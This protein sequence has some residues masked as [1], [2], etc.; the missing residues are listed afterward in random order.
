LVLERHGA[1]DMRSLALVCAAT[2]LALAACLSG[3][4]TGGEPLFDAG[5]PQPPPAGDDAGIQ[6]PATWTALYKDYFGRGAA[7]SCSRATTCHGAE[8]HGG[9]KNSGFLC[10]PDGDPSDAGADGDAAAEA[11]A[12]SGQDRCYAGITNPNAGLVTP[13]DAKTFD[14]TGLYAVLRKQLPD[15]GTSGFM[16]QGSAFTF[17]TI[18]IKRLSDWYAAGAKND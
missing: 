13:G 2:A 10:P 5:P 1:D 4:V 16:P 7:A 18:D 3:N 15:S 17:H 14:K 6:G 11:G 9:F 8:D 12:T